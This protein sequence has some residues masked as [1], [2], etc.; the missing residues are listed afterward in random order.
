MVSNVPSFSAMQGFTPTGWL[1]ECVHPATS[2]R[3]PM[4][5]RDQSNSLDF[6]VSSG[7]GP[8]HPQPPQLPEV[9]Q[10]PQNYLLSTVNHNTAKAA[11]ARTDQKMEPNALETKTVLFQFLLLGLQ[12]QTLNPR[13]S[14]RVLEVSHLLSVKA[15]NQSH[16]LPL[17]PGSILL[18]H[19]PPC[20]CLKTLVKLSSLQDALV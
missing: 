16:L 18:S 13:G 2:S 9:S 1:L 4:Q 7:S 5:P 17:K 14:K 19:S 11:V 6:Q 12:M 15:G 3:E 20:L 10:K 8:L